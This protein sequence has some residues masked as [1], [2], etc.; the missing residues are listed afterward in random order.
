MERRYMNLGLI[1]A[2][3]NKDEIKT[4]RVIHC[5]HHLKRQ[6][7]H[8]TVSPKWTLGILL[9]EDSASALAVAVRCGLQAFLL[10]AKHRATLLAFFLPEDELAHRD[11]RT[12]TPGAAA[13]RLSP[14]HRLSLLCLKLYT[15]RSYKKKT[16]KKTTTARCCQHWLI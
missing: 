5:W 1:A 11:R 4:T 12:I 8:Y 3:K 2:V 15:R 13:H 9:T 6:C 7:S 10:V 14:A 16:K